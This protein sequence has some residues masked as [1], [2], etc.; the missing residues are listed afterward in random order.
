MMVLEK[1]LR[2]CGDPVTYAMNVE[3]KFMEIFS[4]A[5]RINLIWES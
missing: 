2:F 1:K 3:T 5:R 4:K